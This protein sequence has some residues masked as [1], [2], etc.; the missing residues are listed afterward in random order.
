[1]LLERVLPEFDVRSRHAIEIDAPAERVAHA[2]RAYRPLH[3]R[4]RLVLCIGEAGKA[5]QIEESLRLPAA[6]AQRRQRRMFA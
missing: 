4:K 1:M 3:G 2:A 5:A 6:I